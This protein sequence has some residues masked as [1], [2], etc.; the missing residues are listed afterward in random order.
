MRKVLPGWKI[1][2]IEKNR[3]FWTKYGH[4]MPKNW[5]ETTQNI[6]LETFQKFEWHVGPS[7]S[8]N[9]MDYMIHTRPSGIRVSRLNRIP[10]LVA[11]AQIPIIGPWG[12]RITKREAA[13]A[14][15]FGPD[16]KLHST[17]SIAYRQLGN[18]VNVDVVREIFWK[19]R[20]L[21]VIMGT[22]DI[23]AETQYP[24]HPEYTE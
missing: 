17:R 10:A 5:L 11:M 20:E 15:S 7:S 8:R 22:D 4:L 12:R 23:R 19:L 1:K 24:S 18:S 14:Q 6:K 16:F 2:F 9:V 3:K 21:E 13:N